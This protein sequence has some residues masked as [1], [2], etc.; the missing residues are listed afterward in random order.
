MY[1]ASME[2]ILI[3]SNMELISHRVPAEPKVGILR[4]FKLILPGRKRYLVEDYPPSKD[5]GME[6]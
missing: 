1:D 6:W 5:G 3:Y 2:I 4:H